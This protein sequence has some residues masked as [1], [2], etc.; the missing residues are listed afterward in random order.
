MDDKR[1]RFEGQVLPHLDAAYRFARWLCYSPGDADDV[2]QEAVL[3]AF[4]GFDG[5]RGSDAK[6]WLLTI[7]RNCHLTAAKQTQR[8]AAV[9]LPE[10]NDGQDASALVETAPGPEESTILSDQKKLLD[11]LIAGLPE[12]QRTVL[13]LREIEE[14]DYAQI[15]AVTQV[16]IGTVMS[17]L[18]RSRAALKTRWLQTVEGEPR[19]VR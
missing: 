7:V 14:M 16:P 10:E 5:L 12:E 2:V 13:M 15:A 17:R 4:R 9:P 18:A 11:K 8:R 19:A 3:R 6:S 1:A